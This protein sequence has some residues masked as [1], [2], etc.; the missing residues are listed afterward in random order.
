VTAAAAAGQLLSAAVD[1]NRAAWQ[2]RICNSGLPPSARLVA[3]ALSVYSDPTGGQGVW[4]SGSELATVTGIRTLTTVSH[5][6]RMLVDAGYLRKLDGA[7]Y[8]TWPGEGP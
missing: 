7:W 1:R 5:Y 2:H 3:L 4:F 6:C 8:L